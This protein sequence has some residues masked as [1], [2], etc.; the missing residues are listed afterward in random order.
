MLG[1]SGKGSAPKK[2]RQFRQRLHA[3]HIGIIHQQRKFRPNFIQKNQPPIIGIPQLAH[4]RR[5][6]FKQMIGNLGQLPF[7]QSVAN[8]KR[9]QL[10]KLVLSETGEGLI[11]PFCKGPGRYRGDD[12]S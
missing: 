4:K 2:L 12:L 11:E 7:G 10:K 9:V 6:R 8:D 3:E 1:A 5:I